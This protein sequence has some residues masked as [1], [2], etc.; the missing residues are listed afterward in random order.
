MTRVGYGRIM[1]TVQAKGQATSMTGEGT[2]NAMA[3]KAANMDVNSGKEG[4][5]IATPP[6]R[7]WST[8]DWAM[9]GRTVWRRPGHSTLAA[10]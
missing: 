10:L 5:D 2:H 3:L 4:K 1:K 7:S 8:Q 6:R 9:T